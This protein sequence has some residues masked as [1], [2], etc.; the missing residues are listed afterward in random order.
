MIS[1]DL[2][3]LF[4]ALLSIFD[5]VLP[6][7][8]DVRAALLATGTKTAEYTPIPLPDEFVDILNR[9]DAHPACAAILNTPLPWAPPTT[10]DSDIYREH[11][12]GKVHVEVFGPDGLVVTDRTRLGLYGTPPKF[13]YG[14]RNHPAE[15][16]YV[17]LAGEAYWACGEAEYAPLGPGARSHHPSMAPHANRTASSPFLAAYAWTGDISTENYDYSGQSAAG[18]LPL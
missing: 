12:R 7:E 17:M 3:E 9:D 18:G 6:I 4:D 14:L 16:I 10:V 8:K 2:S 11:S 13:E 5:G 1:T 15:E